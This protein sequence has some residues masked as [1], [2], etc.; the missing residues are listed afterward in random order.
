MNSLLLVETYVSCTVAYRLRLDLDTIEFGK[1]YELKEISG[2]PSIIIFA[3]KKNKE[4]M[5]E[6]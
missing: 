4:N 5:Q 3:S 2:L 1:I 6:K